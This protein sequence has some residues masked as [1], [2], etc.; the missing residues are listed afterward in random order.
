MCWAVLRGPAGKLLAPMLPDLVSM[1]RAEKALDLTDGQAELLGRMSAATIDGRLSGRR[2]KL[3]PRGR[4]HTKPGSLLKSQIPVR[5]WAQWDNAVP[6]FVE[7]DLVGH[8]SRRATLDGYDYG[9][10]EQLNE[11]RIRSAFRVSRG[12]W[13]ANA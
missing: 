11:G 3:L 9:A 5:T 12:V 1:L 13:P 7:I 6:G 8:D 2:A 4:S 10:E